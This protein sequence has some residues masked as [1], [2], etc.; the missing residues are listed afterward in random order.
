MPMEDMKKNGR[1]KPHAKADTKARRITNFRSFNPTKIER[2]AIREDDRPTDEIIANLATFLETGI[3]KMSFSWS[4]DRQSFCLIVR[5]G[6]LDWQEALALSVWHVDMLTCFKT[7]EYAL[8]GPFRGFPEEPEDTD[9][10]DLT[11]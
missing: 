1:Q 2:L 5:D 10:D 7:M 6:K 11:W 4:V 8:A 3:L 9:P